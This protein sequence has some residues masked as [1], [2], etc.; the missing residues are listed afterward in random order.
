MN[1]YFAIGFLFVF[2][3]LT[4]IS[5]LCKRFTADRVTYTIYLITVTILWPFFAAKI[6][7]DYFKKK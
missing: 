7:Y 3:F 6:A 5:N 1:I 4:E 2:I